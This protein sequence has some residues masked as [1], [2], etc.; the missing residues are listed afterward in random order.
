MDKPLQAFMKV[1]VVHFMAYPAATKGERVLETLREIVE[2]A[3]FT[4]VEVTHVPDPEERQRVADLLSASGM[5][6][7]YGAQPLQ[8]AGKLDIGAA[9]PERRASA[10]AV[11]REAIDEAYALGASRFA[12]LSGPSVE[13]DCQEQ[14]VARTVQS[15]IELCRYSRSRGN[16]PVCLETFD[17]D[18]DKR[19]LIGP[20][21]LATQ[22]SARVRE[23]EPSFGLML[24]LS[25]IPLQHETIGDALRAAAG[26]IVHAH[27]GNCVMRDPSHP[28]YGDQ[29]PRFGHPA[30]ENG[31]PELMEYLRRLIEVGYLKEGEPR[32]VGFEVKP[33]PGEET[34]VVLANAKRALLEAW[35]LA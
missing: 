19:A 33:T 35:A 11:L 17:Y 26:H 2:D 14:A 27:V 29:H 3:F 10:V 32:V 1:G 6:V 18:I 9:D 23:A 4:A 30:G 15:L 7:G 8:L 12:V 25:H 13:P 20:N 16:M 21:A 22:L 24:D 34:R 31:V 5:T 28:L